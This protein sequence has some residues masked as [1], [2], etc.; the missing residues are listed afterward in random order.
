MSRSGDEERHGA[1]AQAERGGHEVRERAQT[2]LHSDSVEE[3]E[4]GAARAQAARP[5]AGLTDE[6]RRLETTLAELHRRHDWL[7]LVALEKEALALAQQVR[8]ADPG[9]AE[10]IHGIRGLA[11]RNVGAAA[12]KLP[13]HAAVGAFEA[14]VAD[15]TRAQAVAAPVAAAR[16]KHV[17][18][19]VALTVLCKV[20]FAADPALRVA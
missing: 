3:L 17:A 5:P 13:S 1:A 15:A 9:L 19:E 18:L 11:F 16:D 7:G 20:V 14:R 2:G 4:G 12:A 10:S 6:Q 8:G